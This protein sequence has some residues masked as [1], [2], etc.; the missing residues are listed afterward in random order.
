MLLS[1]S[2]LKKDGATKKGDENNE[3]TSGQTSSTA[4]G[5]AEP[6][7]TPSGADGNPKVSGNNNEGGEG[8]GGQ[9]EGPSATHELGFGAVATGENVEEGDEISF[10]IRELPIRNP[11]E[12]FG[13]DAREDT[14]GVCL[15][16]AAVVLARW[17]ASAEVQA[18]LDGQ[19]VIDLGA[20]CGAG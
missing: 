6:S 16:A 7:E 14:T 3:E 15:W 5:A 2:N 8:Q 11:D 13:D 1:Q 20:G 10:L 9:E 17:M 19:T 4:S 12:C 18:R